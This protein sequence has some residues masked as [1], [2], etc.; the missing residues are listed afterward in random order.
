MA[1]PAQNHQYCSQWINDKEESYPI[2]GDRYLD[3][4]KFETYSSL[5]ASS[6][7][8]GKYELHR[9][10]L[11]QERSIPVRI[12]R[13]FP[14]LISFACASVSM[15]LAQTSPVTVTVTTTSHG[16]AVPTD[17]SGLGFERGTLNSGNAGA[18]GYIFSPTNIQL[19]TLFQNLGVKNLRIGGG[20]VDD[21]IP[22][23]TGSDGYA[24]IDNLFDFAQ[25]AGVR[26]LY[27]FRLLNPASKPI[28]NLVQDDA[29]AA[30]YIWGKYQPYVH[31]FAIGNEPDFHSYHTS[32]PLIFETT[33]GVPGTAFP[34]YLADW[35]NFA[36]TIE[37][38]APG[39]VFSGPDSGSYAPPIDY[40]GVPWTINFANA[41]NGSG[42]I[43][44]ITQHL[45]VGGSPGSTTAQ[46]A[47]DNELSH[48]WINNPGLA[49]GPEGTSTYT[50]YAWFY[51]NGLAGV[52][53]D[54]LPFRLTESDDYLT[55]INGASNGFA[56]ALWALDYMHWWAAS[57]AA[58][59][60]FHNKQWIFTDTI[61]P[62]PNPCATTCG[63]YQTSPKGYGIK[64]FDLGGHGYAEPVAISNPDNINVTAY[65]VGDARRLYVTIVNKTHST[66]NDT[67]NAVVAI[68]PDGF[69]AGSAS[70]ILLTDGEPGN[71]ALLTAT[72]GG[73]TIPNNARWAGTWIPIGP[74]T[75]GSLQVT[76]PATT[77]VVVKIDAASN[78]VGPVQIN[79]N[80]SLEVFASDQRGN[81]WDNSQLAADVPSSG[82]TSWT[83]WT[84]NLTGVVLSGGAAVAKN[85]DNTLEAFV[86]GSTGDVYHNMQETP[87]GPWSGWSDLGGSGIG[88]LEAA[89]NADGSL[90]VF[91]IGSNGDVWYASENAPEVGWSVW[92]DLTGQTIEP[93]FVVEQNLD[94]L[95]QI[96]GVDQAGNIWTNSQ[97]ANASWG[98]WTQIPGAYLDPRLAAARDLDGSLE[99][100]GVARDG[101]IWR[102]QQQGP[103][104]AWNGWSVMRGPRI[105]PGFV[106]GQSADG[107]LQIFGVEAEGPLPWLHAFGDDTRNIWTISQGTAGGRWGHWSTLGRLV[108]DS[109]LIVGN[110]AD[111]R[112]QIFGASDRGD[113]LSNWQT[114][115]SGEKWAGWSDF[116]G[117][118]LKFYSAQRR[119]T[120]H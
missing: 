38:S 118:G 114:A 102:N 116:G 97:T 64:A 20:S 74:A 110:T 108:A 107:R 7:C 54:N 30:Q 4:E 37:G 91:G 31:S 84:N 6:S 57:G 85:L 68:Q 21:E 109:E 94:G 77:A 72:L 29:A 82:L 89:N 41:E 32:D 42:L 22:V 100:F 79:Q 59:V 48:Q 81:L 96:V 19:V 1:R 49:Q 78:D 39:A 43:S 53:T 87:G 120:A 83:G 24:G 25:A 95:L 62:D 60:N 71:A 18:S 16:A 27:S 55:G 14:G 36:S 44:N 8:L 106:T 93:G 13:Q 12:S 113:V 40:N 5:H 112:M 69:A 98:T 9:A 119:N 105:R 58:G 15:L 17:F 52:N 66:T 45:Y 33:P 11:E 35:Q 26:V 111:G 86:P 117:K 104:G 67:A 92:T 115:P 56:S 70:S 34:S 103:G 28:P 88:S 51:A 23:G 61:V 10:P 47:I 63:N 101:Q 80:G 99:I 76:V 3:T 65:A 46:E 73:A 90:S 50:P 2:L 75:N